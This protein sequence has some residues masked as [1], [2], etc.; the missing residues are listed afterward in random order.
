MTYLHTSSPTRAKLSTHLKSQYKGIKFDVSAAA[1]LV[2]AFTKHN[3]SVDNE[4]LQKLMGSQPDLQAV[5]DFASAAVGKAE[6]LSREA[7]AE[8]ETMTEGLQ[9]TAAGAKTEDELAAKLRPG[10]VYI[11]DIH[12]FKAGL[13]PSKAAVPLEPIKAVAKL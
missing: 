9:G 10:N 4:A 3:V 11:E 7:K 5:K 12:A 2:Q 6:G 8:L 1:S 13:I